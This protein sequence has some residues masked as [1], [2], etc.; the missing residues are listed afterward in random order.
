MSNQQPRPKAKLR[1]RQF[2]TQMNEKFAQTIWTTLRAAIQEIQK[3]NN[4]G[5]SF[6]ELYR[7]AY[8][9][10]LHKKGD[11]L[12]EG[13]REV[14]KEHLEDK[15]RV[16]V[17]DAL[18][19][20]FLQVLN[21]AWN[22]HQ[23]SMV[24][25]R[26][27]LMYM[28]RVYV[29]QNKVD[30]IYNLGLNLFRDHVINYPCIRDHLRHTLLSQVLVERRGECI[31]ALAIKNVCQMLVQLGI[32]R[33]DVYEQIFE[34]PFLEQSSEFYRCESQKFLAENSASTYIRK[35]EQRIEEES[36][37]A[38]RYLDEATE[39]KI[40]HV[41]EEELITKHMTSIVE[42]EN[43]GVVA[44]LRDRKIDDLNCLYKLSCRVPDGLQHVIN[45]V[46]THLREQGKAL[47]S[48][49]EGGKGD[50]VQFIQV[51]PCDKKIPL[52]SLA[53]ICTNS[54]FFPFL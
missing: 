18:N 13:V 14:I 49:E 45:C 27:I 19:N 26:D 30:N 36:E 6:E 1:M 21:K 25:I 33:R 44:M 20:N 46:S 12:Y 42:M 17:L 41:V 51:S 34:K 50:A 52:S 8:T 43:S 15:I 32:D 4:G 38:R 28:D 11:T 7:N 39:A 54:S 16:D 5:L 24:M 22:D 9:L 40:V 35:V 47:V 2:P 53:R 23:T 10:V 48:E 31:E 3:K 29:Q 37:R